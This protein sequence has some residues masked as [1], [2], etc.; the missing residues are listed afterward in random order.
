MAGLTGMMWQMDISEKLLVES[1]SSSNLPMSSGLMIIIWNS[2]QKQ[3]FGTLG[4]KNFGSIVF[5]ADW[6]GLH[7]R[8][9]NTTRL[10]IVSRFI[11]LFKVDKAKAPIEI[12]C[13]MGKV[14]VICE[15]GRLVYKQSGDC[16]LQWWTGSILRKTSEQCSLY[17]DSKCLDYLYYIIQKIFTALK[18]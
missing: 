5:S 9:A 10:A 2:G 1:Q 13:V 15:R 18:G 6:K 14:A 4:F 7:K 16:Y 3:T 8:T 17:W 11:V 12:N